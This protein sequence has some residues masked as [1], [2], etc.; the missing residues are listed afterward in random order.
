MNQRVPAFRILDVPVFIPR[1]AG[2]GVALIA[3]FFVPVAQ[4]V[5][6][7]ETPSWLIMLGALAHALA[8]YVAIFIHELGHTIAA[9]HYGY[10]VEGI[11]IHVVGGHTTFARDFSR[12]R[13]QFITA[14]WGPLA[15]TGLALISWGIALQFQEGIVY[16]V[17]AWLALANAVMS[18]VNLLPGVPLDG[19]AI[20]SAIV[21]R[22]RRDRISGQIAAAI[23]GILI[24]TTWSV[25]PFIFSSLFGWELDTFNIIIS[26]LVGMWLASAAWNTLWRARLLRKNPEAATMSVSAVADS[27]TSAITSE[28][29][30][31]NALDPAELILISLEAITRRAIAVDESEN[32]DGALRK[33]STQKAGA[34][35]VMRGNTAIGIVRDAAIAAVPTE[36]KL[37][38]KVS[39]TARRITDV[40]RLPLEITLNQLEAILRNLGNSEWLVVDTEDKIIGVVLRH[41]IEKQLEGNI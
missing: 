12:S 38:T 32:V 13:H 31:E 28:A 37:S 14:L 36:R 30:V 1:S 7:P 34:I 40:D 4:N 3:W 41:D 17:F 19:G 16:S 33:A 25:S 11:V 6:D 24:A 22:L 23:G 15:T 10:T 5:L 8:I 29:L 21:W 35:V 20:L 2:L 18:G 26:F 27:V 39:A 9:R